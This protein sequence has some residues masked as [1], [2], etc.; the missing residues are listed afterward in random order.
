MLA[1]WLKTLYA[2]I[3]LIAKIWNFSKLVT[4]FKDVTSTVSVIDILHIISQGLKT[5]FFEKWHKR[6]SQKLR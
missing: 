1:T 5:R 6:V 2:K 3:E 4:I